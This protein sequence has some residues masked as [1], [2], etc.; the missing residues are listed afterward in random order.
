MSIVT[1]TWNDN[2]H[3]FTG[4]YGIDKDGEWFVVVKGRNSILDRAAIT[5]LTTWTKQGE[6]QA[7]F[8]PIP[9]IRGLEY[10]QTMNVKVKGMERLKTWY[11]TRTLPSVVF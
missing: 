5:T 10:V 11:R 1:V 2:D 6:F 7:G 8:S 4:V 9:L 3:P